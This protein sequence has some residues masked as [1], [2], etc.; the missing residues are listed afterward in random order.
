MRESGV[1]PGSAVLGPVGGCG[2]ADFAWGR[3]VCIV[4]PCAEARMTE[5]RTGRGPRAWGETRGSAASDR[6]RWS[7]RGALPVEDWG[8]SVDFGPGVAG[9]GGVDTDWP[10]GLRWKSCSGA[11]GGREAVEQMLIATV[12]EFDSDVEETLKTRI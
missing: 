9:R 1:R 4:F 3:M 5:S 12:R 10:A 2:V 6:R 11:G 8:G 7:L